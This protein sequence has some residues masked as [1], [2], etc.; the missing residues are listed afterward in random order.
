MSDAITL[1]ERAKILVM[2]QDRIGDVFVST[3]VLH[4]L[5]NRFPEAQIDVLLSRNNMAA[6]F[7]IE[8]VVDSI[9]I[10]RKNSLQMLRLLWTLRWSRYDVVID[11]NHT[12]SS[13]SNLLIRCAAARH[14]IV[15]ETARPSTA[16]TVVPQGDRSIR[17]IVDV[18]C[19]LLLPL[20]ISIPLEARRPKV[21]VSNEIMTEVRA[22]V[23]FITS[24]QILGVQI[25]GSSRD[26][27]YPIEALEQ[28][29]PAIKE[30]FPSV[31]IVVMSAP[32]ERIQA[33]Q[34]ARTTGAAYVDAGPT[35]Q[36]FAALI[37]S[38]T[39]ILSPDTAAI[40][41]AA[42]HNVP[43]VVLFSRDHRGYVN[44]LPYD[45]PCWPIITEDSSLGSIATEMVVDN[46]AS[47]MTG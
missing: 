21:T 7:A 5:R 20:G 40:H 45:A 22:K 19:D 17:H 30:R 47:M 10:L 31:D 24:K 34:L 27:M 18:L 8:P 41:V 39:W 4:A 33:E 38:C 43:S 13:T 37:A 16:T 26:R 3:A 12:A 11:L 35:Y 2:R 15:L 1:P 29:I 14:S 25:S 23:A 44:W 32:S 42:A 6:S 28:A 46:V 36:H 9:H